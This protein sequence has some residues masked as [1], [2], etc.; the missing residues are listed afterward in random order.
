MDQ[1]FTLNRINI[2]NQK[3][4]SDKNTGTMEDKKIYDITID[5]F[6]FKTGINAISL[7]DVPAVGYDFLAF[8]DDSMRLAFA[9]EEQHI[10][11]GVALLADTPILRR[12]D[13]GSI[14]YIRFSR[15]TIKNIVEKYS[16]MGLNNS[17]N[18]MHNDE[19]FVDGIFLTES[20]IVDKE[21]GICPIEFKD[22]PDGSW[23]V[24]FKVENLSLW[25][26]IKSG[27]VKGFSVQG[28][29]GLNEAQSFSSEENK[30]I[31]NKNKSFK[32]KLIEKLKALIAEFSEV[33]TDKGVL[34][35][36]E[37]GDIQV[38][39]EVFVEG[40][41]GEM[42]P[43]A[44]GEYVVEEKVIV[45]ADGKVAEIRE[46]VEEPA[47]EEVEEP[48]AVE[49]PKEEPVAMADETEDPKEE[50]KPAEETVEDTVV[51]EEP[52]ADP[53]D[54]KIAELEAKIAD[55]EG[56]VAEAEK[57]L[58]E[59]LAKVVEIAETP[60]VEPIAE[61]FEAIRKREEIK[62]KKLAKQMEIYSAMPRK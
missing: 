55:M 47:A 18:L 16:M 6:D 35:Y 39:Y 21:R 40:E 59:V 41:D 43:A 37:E 62:D 27:V 44:D 58:E 12:R 53:R 31:E 26:I 2:N 50:E 48:V 23:I 25:D 17:V 49:E 45:V 5:L 46:K 8:S 32:M 56:R 3:Y 42:V 7:V 33:V 19:L 13:D 11:T 61:E 57:K 15:E 38:G 24:S 52:E 30:P 10:I 60:A 29:F 14:F 28:I 4:I 20:Y 1:S 54:E 36:N 34:S 9:N 22:V 51:V